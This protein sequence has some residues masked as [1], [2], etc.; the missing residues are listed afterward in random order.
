MGTTQHAGLVSSCVR[1]SFVFDFGRPA[2]TWPPIDG[3]VKGMAEP[4]SITIN[5]LHLNLEDWPEVIAALERLFVSVWDRSP[6]LVVA[7]I[8]LTILMPYYWRWSWLRT[9]RRSSELDR[10]ENALWQSLKKARKK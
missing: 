6:P 7:A 5:V 3:I 8:L 4:G 10:T 9:W 1:C 2:W